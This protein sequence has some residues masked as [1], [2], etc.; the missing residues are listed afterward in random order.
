M[1]TDNKY[2]NENSAV[3]YYNNKNNSSIWNFINL[4]KNNKFINQ[5][6]KNSN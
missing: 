5:V 1:K 6:N 2:N 4:L 3:N